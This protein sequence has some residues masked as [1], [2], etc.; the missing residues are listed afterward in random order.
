MPVDP[1]FFSI[2]QEDFPSLIC[3]FFEHVPFARYVACR[4]LDAAGL[5]I[6]PKQ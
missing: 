6:L 1:A 2:D 3:R 5:I 4:C